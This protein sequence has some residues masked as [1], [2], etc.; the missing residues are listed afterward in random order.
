MNRSLTTIVGF[1]LYSLIV[2][3]IVGPEVGGWFFPTRQWWLLMFWV[4]PPFL[5][6]TLRPDIR[7]RK[8]SVDLHLDRIA[9]TLLDSP[10]LKGRITYV[11]VAHSTSPERLRTHRVAQKSA[12]RP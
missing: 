4:V 5:V 6:L 8:E 3:T 2:N 10:E 11:T 1:G 7:R 12:S 9:R